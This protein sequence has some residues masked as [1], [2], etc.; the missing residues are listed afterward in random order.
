MWNL[1]ES[2]L[3]NK[4][5]IPLGKISQILTAAPYGLNDFS[6]FM[7]IMIFCESFA[8]TTRLELDGSKLST[9]AWAEQV[10]EDIAGIAANGHV[11]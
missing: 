7:L 1:L 10:V 6:A 3:N 5:V 4:K 8:Y 11:Q 9:N 2:T